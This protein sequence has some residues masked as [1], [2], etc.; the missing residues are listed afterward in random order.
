VAFVADLH[1]VRFITAFRGQVLEG[2]VVIISAVQALH[3][4]EMPVSA[5]LTTPQMFGE[6]IPLQFRKRGCVSAY[7]TETLVPG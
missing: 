7:K 5:A 6:I 1:P 2:T 3:P 4:G